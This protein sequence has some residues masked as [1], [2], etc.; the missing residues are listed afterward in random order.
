MA[1]LVD[2]SK[3]RSLQPTTRTAISREVARRERNGSDDPVTVHQWK[4]F[5]GLALRRSRSK[6]HYEDQINV[7]T[8]EHVSCV[9]PYDGQ[10][11][12]RGQTSKDKEDSK[13]GEDLLVVSPSV[14]GRLRN[15][16]QM[17]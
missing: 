6:A 5:A 2:H 15:E 4:H 12:R 9:D 13:T 10:S 3:T 16:A 14:D 8:R 1:R 17:R 7:C 11:I